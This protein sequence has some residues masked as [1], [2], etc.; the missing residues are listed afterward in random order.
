M[1]VYKKISIQLAGLLELLQYLSNSWLKKQI[2]ETK[3]LNTGPKIPS[4]PMQGPANSKC[5]I[6]LKGLIYKNLQNAAKGGM[7]PRPMIPTWVI[8]CP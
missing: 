1:A 6:E 7:A 8:C 2:V 4:R 5:P 3:M